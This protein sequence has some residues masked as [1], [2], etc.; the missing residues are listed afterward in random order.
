MLKIIVAGCRDFN[1]YEFVKE[2]LTLYI[3]QQLEEA[4]W[5]TVSDIEI[6]EGGAKGVDSL[7]RSFCKEAK[8]SHTTFHANWDRLNKGAGPQRNRR[9]AEYGQYL[10]AFW[11]GKSRGTKDM[12][13]QAKKFNVVTTVVD[14]P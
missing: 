2:K 11:D 6:I 12:I 14:I 9:M 5:C 13:E 10:I 4:S 7:A 8:L 1:D 3:A